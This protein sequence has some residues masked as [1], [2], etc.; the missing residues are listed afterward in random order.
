MTFVIERNRFAV[1][2]SLTT[3]LLLGLSGC[4]ADEN[5]SDQLAR[6][7]AKVDGVR[8]CAAL[9]SGSWPIEASAD[10]LSGPH[11]DA[12]VAA[13]LVRRVTMNVPE[14]DRART[15]IELT[16]A[17]QNHILIERV[18]ENT[19]ETA[20]LCYGRLQVISLNQ[21]QTQESKTGDSSKLNNLLFYNY[22]IVQ[23][24]AWATRADIRAAFPFMVQDLEQVHSEQ[25]SEI[26]YKNEKVYKTPS[27]EESFSA[28]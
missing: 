17:G 8:R 23:P 9:L 20:V 15:R 3:A 19:P 24:P 27:T 28:D 2:C 7:R 22:R 5:K 13:G 16:P 11:V 25:D 14:G 21:K 1:F 12:L 4:G 6:I 26:L 18:T 10:S